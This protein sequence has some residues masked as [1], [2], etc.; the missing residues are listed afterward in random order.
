MKRAVFPIQ[1]VNRLANLLGCRRET[2]AELADAPAANYRPMA[3]E[4]PGKKTRSISVPV[5][6]LAHVQRRIFARVLCDL[7]PH[8]CSLGGIKG[9]TIADNARAHGNSPYILKIDVRN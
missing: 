2:L 9:R 6:E 7:K 3:L 8:P 5:Q 4:R 1:S